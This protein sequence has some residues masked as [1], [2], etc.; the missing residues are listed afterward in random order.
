MKSDHPAEQ[1][2][3]MGKPRKMAPTGVLSA[4][5][6]SSTLSTSGSHENHFAPRKQAVS[7]N[8]E[9]EPLR[10]AIFPQTT[11]AKLSPPVGFEPRLTPRVFPFRA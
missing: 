7:E 5:A 11:P 2:V 9:T 8:D 6:Y 10:P 1:R 4:A 3:Y